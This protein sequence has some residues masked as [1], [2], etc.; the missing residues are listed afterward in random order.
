MNIEIPDELL[1]EIIKQGKEGARLNARAREAIEEGNALK[2]AALYNRSDAGP[3]TEML[4]MAR[5]VLPELDQ[6]LSAPAQDD[7]PG[8]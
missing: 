2:A 5:S 1:P 7:P 3:M 4:N 8:K 6:A